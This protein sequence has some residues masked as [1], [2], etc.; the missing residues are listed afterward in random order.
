MRGNSLNE[1][2]LKH[3]K[4]KENIIYGIIIA[5]LIV[6]LFLALT[7]INFVINYRLDTYK[8]NVMSR[9][10]I[11][12]GRSINSNTNKTSE[13]LDEIS[14]FDYVVTN[15]SELYYNPS[16]QF[17]SELDNG[18]LKGYIQVNAI[19]GEDTIKIINGRL[20]KNENEIVVPAKFYPHGE[21]DIDK[22]KILNGKN[23]IG[24]TI[25]LYS[26]K[27][28]FYIEP[29]D[30]EN[31]KNWYNNR[32]KIDFEIVGT[33]DSEIGMYQRNT[34]FSTKKAIQNLKA[35]HVS[36][37][38]NTLPD[39]TVEYTPNEYGR[40]IIVD[41][42]KNVQKV[43]DYLTEK[44]YEN[45]IVMSI[46]EL[47]YGVLI[48]I[49]LIISVIILII[50]FILIKSFINK[51]FQNNKEYFGLLKVLGYDNKNI[52]KIILHENILVVFLSII[53]ALFLYITL[54]VV[55]ND[56][57]SIITRIDYFS[58]TIRKPY[59]YILIA[60]IIFTLYVYI[61]NNKLSNKFLLKSI[62]ELLKDE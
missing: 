34:C 14:S 18:N 20:P 40:M 1:I 21:S 42:F 15:I 28:Y 24:K 43:S 51:K 61:I 56:M 23:M 12:T 27:G 3:L 41:K 17:V 35:E 58:V 16:Y 60:T 33:Y 10:I 46:D 57:S 7:V 54:F 31:T 37:S 44:N 11:V 6:I 59:L 5:V 47:E 13:E 53:L 19:I 4:R 36:S 22:N 30:K 38:W 50:T 48:L 26:E 8:Y 62:N 9:I 25:T 2:S 32:E 29:S 49:P 45:F 52:K 55:I 39:G